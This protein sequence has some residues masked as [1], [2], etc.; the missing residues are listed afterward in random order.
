MTNIP[1]VEERIHENELADLRSQHAP[2]MVGRFTLHDGAFARKLFH[3]ES[4]S[5]GEILA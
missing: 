5:H 1:E 2:Q 3:E 4:P